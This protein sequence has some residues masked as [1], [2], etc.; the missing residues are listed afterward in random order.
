MVFAFGRERTAKKVDPS[1]FQD[2]VASRTSWQPCK[3]GGTETFLNQKLNRVSQS[4]LEYQPNILSIVYGVAIL[5]VGVYLIFTGIGKSSL[6]LFGIGAFVCIIPIIV[7]LLLYSKKIFDKKVGYYWEGNSGVRQAKVRYKLTDIYA[8]QII[9]EEVMRKGNSSGYFTSYELNMV[10][11]D[12]RRHNLVDHDGYE[13]IVKEA[14][15]LS[16]FLGIPIWNAV[17][18]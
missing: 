5:L 1:I 14:Q 11:A 8:L 15:M 17:E 3:S 16:K 18:P 12:C 10:L 13:S 7:L 6:E 2:N 4:R 9:E